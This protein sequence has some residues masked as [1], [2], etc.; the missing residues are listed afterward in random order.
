[1]MK[2]HLPFV[3]LVA[4]APVTDVFA[5][6]QGPPLSASLERC[7]R[8]NAPRVEAAIADLNAG[9]D[10]IVG[11]LCAGPI[12]A[13]QADQ[14]AQASE[15]QRAKLA[16]YCAEAHQ[17][18][19]DKQEKTLEDAY[20]GEGFK[21]GFLTEPSDVG[22]YTIYGPGPRPAAAVALAAQLLLDLRLSHLKTVGAH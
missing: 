1:M 7:I 8:D 19:K 17:P 3:L 10:F 16:Q 12:A 5:Q 22:S 21:I 20:C 11:D 2:R 6:D 13:E 18:P 15:K 9:V 14:M 4:I